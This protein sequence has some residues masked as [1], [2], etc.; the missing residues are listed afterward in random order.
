MNTRQLVEMTQL[1]ENDLILF[2][3]KNVGKTCRI[4][5][6]Q[7][8]LCPL[9]GK[10]LKPSDNCIA[11]WLNQPH[12]ST[13]YFRKKPNCPKNDLSR[14][15]HQKRWESLWD[16]LKSANTVSAFGR[17]VEAY[18]INSC[19]VNQQNHIKESQQDHGIPQVRI[20]NNVKKCVLG[21]RGLFWSNYFS[22][23]VC[24]CILY[25]IYLDIVRYISI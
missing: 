8:K 4:V 12:R 24:L 17:R 23:K 10:R 22:V 6:N 11:L 15:C 14:F 2:C 20:T 5:W 16:R 13:M 9:W 7:P 18:L 19:P 3:H 21:A 1:P 25:N